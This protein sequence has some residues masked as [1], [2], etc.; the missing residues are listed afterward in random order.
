MNCNV[1]HLYKCF[2]VIFLKHCP[3]Q[4]SKAI[5]I[6]ELIKYILIEFALEPSKEVAYC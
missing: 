4:G 1:Q 3:Y 2:K 6:I 5:Q